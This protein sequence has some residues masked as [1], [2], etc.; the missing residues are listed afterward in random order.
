MLCTVSSLYHD[1]GA[2]VF[3]PSLFRPII[4][5]KTN[6]HSIFRQPYTDEADLGLNFDYDP[7]VHDLAAVT[8]PLSLYHPAVC[9]HEPTLPSASSCQPEPVKTLPATSPPKKL[10]WM[11]KRIRASKERV[12]QWFE[13]HYYVS[14]SQTGIVTCATSPGSPIALTDQRTPASSTAN[15]YGPVQTPPTPAPR[16]KLYLTEKRTQESKERVNRWL[17]EYC[18]DSPAQPCAITCT[19]PLNRTANPSR[20]E[21]TPYVFSHRRSLVPTPPTTAPYKKNTWMNTGVQAWNKTANSWMDKH[22]SVN[23]TPHSPSP[24]QE[25]P[26]L[27]QRATASEVKATKL[28]VNIRASIERSKQATAEARRFLDSF[29]HI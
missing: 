15:Q 5:F 19:P 21:T 26:H 18:C 11:E 24:C 27:V 29:H 9:I 6:P 23:V 25:A 3:T 16:K 22:N 10:S 1:V 20:I 8:P 7:S 28:L 4:H 2:V 13:N 17:D 12:N 14:P